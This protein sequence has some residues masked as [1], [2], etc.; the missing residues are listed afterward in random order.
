MVEDN[1]MKNKQIS[2]L[3]DIVK[4]LLEEQRVLKE[5][6][7]SQERGRKD[8]SESLEVNM[9]MVRKQREI[10]KKA[11]ERTRSQNP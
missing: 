6:I 5:K 7:E 3:S 8:K 11:S 2:E 9:M 4:V 10:T 1:E